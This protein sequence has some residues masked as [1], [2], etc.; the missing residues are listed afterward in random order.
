MRV[1]IIVCADRDRARFGLRGI[2]D[3]HLG[4]LAAGVLLLPLHHTERGGGI[5]APRRQATRDDGAGE[6]RRWLP[7]CGL[8]LETEHWPSPFLSPCDSLPTDVRYGAGRTPT[9]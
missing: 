6:R 2:E 5:V 7:H 8:A 3:P 4:H 9:G 1:E